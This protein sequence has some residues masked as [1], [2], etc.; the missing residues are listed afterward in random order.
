MANS[1]FETSNGGTLPAAGDVVVG[2]DLNNDGIDDIVYGGGDVSV[3]YGRAGGFDPAIDLANLDPTTGFTLLGDEGLEFGYVIAKAENLLRDG[4]D[5]LLIGARQ[6]GTVSV[7]FAGQT[8]AT[9]TVTGLPE[10]ADGMSLAGIGDFNGDGIGDFAIGA[11]DANTGD[12]AVYV[13]Y[14]QTG[15]S[16]TTLD[17]NSLLAADGF[18]INGF[19]ENDFAGTSI[20]GGFD[21]DNDGI[22]DLLIGAPGYDAGIGGIEAGAVYILHGSTTIPSGDG[23]ALA[24]DNAVFETTSYFGFG[25]SELGRVVSM[26]EDVNGDGIADIIV[27]A[28]L[29]GDPVSGVAYVVFGGGTPPATLD[30]LDG[31]NG[32]KISDTSV[33]SAQMLGDVSGDGIG[34]IG[35][36]SNT[37]DIF[38]VF[39]TDTRGADEITGTTDDVPFVVDLDTLN[40]TNGIALTGLF[41]AGA[42]IT[43][44]PLGDVNSDA[45]GPIS[46]IGIFATVAGAASQSYTILGGAANFATLDEA[47]GSIDNKIDFAALPADTEVAFVPD[48]T[49]ITV[50]GAT[51]GAITENDPGVNGAIIVRSSNP[52]AQPAPSFIA[53]T[54]AGLYGDFTLVADGGDWEWQYVPN[55]LNYLNAGEVITDTVTFVADN[56]QTRREVTVTITGVDDLAVLSFAVD[57][58]GTPTEDTGQFSGLITL[59]DPDFGANPILVATTIKGT[60]G[61]ITVNTDGSFT[62]VLTDATLQSRLGDGGGV[63][64]TIALTVTD[65]DLPSTT[66]DIDIVL[67]GVDEDF[68]PTYSDDPNVIDRIFTS[69]GNDVINA[70]AGDD[71][72]NAGGGSDTVNAGAGDDTVFD[73]LGNDIVDGGDGNDNIRLLSGNND[74][75]G[76]TGA[77]KIVTGFGYDVIDGGA[78][79]DVIAADEGSVFTF[80]NNEIT[81]GDDDDIMMGGKG[82]DEFIFDIDD[83]NDTIGAFDH[84][85]ATLNGTLDGYDVNITGAAFHVGVDKIVL[86][87]AGAGSLTFNYDETT[88]DTTVNWGNT[89]I[90]VIDVELTASDFIFV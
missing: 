75:N 5:A 30:D 2:L 23:T 14:G 78:G 55:D 63:T 28:P 11:P 54:L 47:D 32:F 18:V 87:G 50:T 66:Y 24:F 27:T 89:E 3:V 6:A 49:T 36:V 59:T 46:D 26:G 61:I 64:D 73:P 25:G 31:T 20:A 65:G 90:I 86:Q 71:E 17:V 85:Q 51:T 80:G 9:F 43:L 45:S 40:G 60:Y 88:R 82:V 56:N 35:I 62:Y 33:V 57:G 12:G 1:F 15:L 70:M 42:S 67:A 37:G 52:T 84:T 22:S 13:I 7:V 69:F 53:G 77:D 48:D 76:N 41:P 39:G 81:G 29:E 68:V 38:I 19:G 4:N 74:V 10:D 72:I 44:A 83:G 79:N 34:D 21:V 8:E 16:G 58:G